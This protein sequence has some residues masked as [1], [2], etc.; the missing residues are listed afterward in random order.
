MAIVESI[1]RW[2]QTELPPWQGDAVRRLL[3]QE[4]LAETDKDELLMQ[5]KAAHG[6]LATD[7]ISAPTPVKH[8]D[9]SGVA[10]VRARVTLKA[11]SDLC[12][13]NAIPDGSYLPLGHEGL[14]VVY[15]EN[16]AGK[17]GYARVLKRACKARDN[18]EQIR[19]NIYG[20]S[21]GPAAA[22]FKISINGGPDEELRW[23]DRGSANNSLANIAV[24][25]SKCARVIVD[26]KNKLQYL[27]YGA[28]VF[29]GLVALLKDLKARLEREKP[30]PEVPRC[31]DILPTTKAAQSIMALSDRTTKIMIEQITTWSEQDEDRLLLLQTQITRAEA[32]DPSKLAGRLLK[33]KQRIED[34]KERVAAV[35]A[36]TSAAK[37]ETL[38]KIKGDADSAEKAVQIVSQETL[39]HEPLLGAGGGAWQRL[40][41]AAKAYST[42]EAY[43]GKE[44]PQTVEG[45]R[46]VLCMQPIAQDARARFDRF[47]EFMERTTT[48]AADSARAALAE[49]IRELESLD[50]EAPK[51]YKD[52]VDE[53]RDR[54]ASLA[55]EIERYFGAM[56]NRAGDILKGIKGRGAVDLAPSL[57]S[58]SE[59]ITRIAQSLQTEAELLMKAADPKELTEL[60]SERNEL[61]ARRLANGRQR[62]IIRYVEDL[63]I[64]NKYDCCIDATKHAAITKRG[65]E[66]ISAA[67]TEN[68]ISL[69]NEELR[70]LGLVRISISVVPSGGYGETCHQ[71]A[72]PNVH[73]PPKTKLTEI[74]S[75]GELTVVGIAGFL[76]EL[77][78]AGHDG[79]IVFDDPVCSLDHKYRERVAERLAREA[80]TRQVI[81]FTHD[82]AF[83]SELELK[84]GLLDNVKFF[85]Q[86]VRHDTAPGQCA[87]GLPW[88]CMPVK[89]RLSY[90]NERLIEVLPLYE[91][92]RDVYN[93]EAACMYAL[94]RETWEAAI[95]E[96]L[97]HKVV[98]RFSGEVHT[99]DLR[100]VEVT[101]ED[102]KRVYSGMT[103]CSQWMS[104]HDKAKPLDVDRPTPFEIQGDIK[105]LEGFVKTIG[106]RA[107]ATGT[108]RKEMLKPQVPET[109]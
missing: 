49:A 29:E 104:G 47:K 68:L 46:C 8:G 58:P 31:D 97:F 22:T 53:I 36:G 39:A 109:G 4:T 96:I 18:K 16:A 3:T 108:K 91:G 54:D 51:T 32:E 20:R 65:T 75:E 76:A 100:Y 12:N 15:G 24:F 9:L 81:V 74:F 2:A 14:T 85:A 17:S 89:K 88:H 56:R 90:L 86:T 107:E 52:A 66:I 67:M 95:E 28:H 1:I 70:R 71:F 33:R 59:E 64:A 61:Q 87:R 101:D 35:E 103:K 11:I 5:L 27:P 73:L 94:L 30:T 63:R 102:H 6:L 57:S 79:A 78:M 21:S 37:A 69:I 72:L 77:K 105:D 25:D 23:E 93:R 48:K 55:D 40:Y 60:R 10:E 62:E 44:F 34:L 13:V 50:F 43:P 42:Q 19:P 26:E 80:A 92:N 38:R 106:L 45:S 7:P 82:I 99:L 98:R 84:A 41:E 83:L